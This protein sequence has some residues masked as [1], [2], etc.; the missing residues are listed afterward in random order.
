[1]SDLVMPGKS[2]GYSDIYLDFLA[3]Q[4]S[5]RRFF[6]AASIEDVAIGLDTVSY[7]REQ[8]VAALERQNRLFG[9]SDETFANIEKLKDKKALCAFTSQQACLFGGPLLIII[10]ALAIVKAAHR[11]SEQLKRPVV[12]VFWIAGD[13]HDFEEVNHTYML[14]HKGEPVKIIYG[15][16]PKV[17]LPTAEIKFS[18]KAELEK[19]KEAFKTTLGDTDFTPNLYDLIDSSYTSDSTFVSAFGKLMASLTSKFGLILFSPGDPAVKKLAAPFFMDILNKQDELH[20]VITATNQH[21]ERQGYHLQVQKKDNSTHLF[22]NLD[23][24]RPIT[25]EGDDFLIG[26]KHY[27]KEELSKYINKSPDR[28][29]PDVMLRPVLQSYL[30]PVLTQKGGPSEIAYLAQV[31]PIFSL[32]GLV[33]PY[34]MARPSLTF[35]EKRFEKLMAEH[36]ISFE[37]LIGDI[38]QV[39]NRVLARSFPE[40]LESKFEKFKYD[41]KRSFDENL[42]EFLTFDPALKQFASQTYGKIDFS[43]KQFEAKVFVS[44]KKK[45]KQTR[46][47]I[48]RLW[49]TMFPNRALQER[50]L[51]IMYFLARYGQ[52]FLS[53]MYDKMDCEEKAHQII[54]LSE[55]QS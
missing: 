6:P 9:A 50:S 18:D 46:D 43:L 41:L 25:R 2:L 26:D 54:H 45:S 21:I 34:Y 31:N 32:F 35:L 14:N 15:T 49:H 20:D 27:T 51:N 38:E 16:P 48:Y 5:A 28:V 4:D 36:R 17:E 10:K 13:D 37:E 8:I 29:S 23:G 44:H 7:D 33:S 30:F 39:I 55:F 24:R 11:Y 40:N 42:E 3:G 53:F 22:L 52:D 19:A 12:P 47:R 1:M